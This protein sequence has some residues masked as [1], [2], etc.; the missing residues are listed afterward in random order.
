M[1]DLDTFLK[2]D[3]APVD[4]PEAVEPQTVE[5]PAPETPEVAEAPKGPVRDEKGRF[6]PK[7][8][9]PEGESPTP[10][11]PPLDHAALI[12]ERR[13]RQEAEQRIAEYETRLAQLQQPQPQ[14]TPTQGPPDRWED[15]EGYDQWLV[16]RATNL[17]ASAARAEAYQ[18]FQYQRIQLSAE[19]AKARLPDYVEKI[20]VFDQMA[21]LNPMLLQ[22]LA[23]APN[24]AEYAYNTAKTQIELNTYGGIDGLIAARVQEAL[25]QPQQAQTPIPE[26]LASEQSARTNVQALHVPSLDEILK[27]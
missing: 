20:G 13:R 21:Q 5:A 10:A 27:R 16:A 18:A 14:A 15:P 22:E 8:E 7:G 11:E 23:R 4:A 17:A 1:D 26:T 2:G 25:K 19:E 6:A 24:P 3:E 12:G 9:Q